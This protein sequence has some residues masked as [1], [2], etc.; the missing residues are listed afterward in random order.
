M[1]PVSVERYAVPMV[2]KCGLRKTPYP[3]PGTQITYTV[4]LFQRLSSLSL[5]VGKR[6]T[7]IGGMAMTGQYS[8][9]EAGRLPTMAY[10]RR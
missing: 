4:G 6:Y 2:G 5:S 3:T 7:L 10:T 1:L 8:F 9:S